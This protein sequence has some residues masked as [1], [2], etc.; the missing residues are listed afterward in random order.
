MESVGKCKFFIREKFQWLTTKENLLQFANMVVYILLFTKVCA[1]L[2]YGAES[3]YQTFRD[4]YF[5][6]AVSFF[7]IFILIERKVNLLSKPIFITSITYIGIYFRHFSVNTYELEYKADLQAQW[8]AWGLFLLVMVDIIKTG[9]R[10]TFNCKNKIFC[11]IMSIAF[12]LALVSDINYSLSM[13]CPFL[14]LY[15]T[16]ISKKRWEQIIDCFTIGYYIAFAK[17]MTISLIQVPYDIKEGLF[18]YYGIFLNI[19]TGGMLC[20]GAF[21]CAL[22]WFIKIIM[23]KRHVAMGVFLCLLAMFYS[24]FATTLFASRTAE[25]GIVCAMLCSLIFL[26]RKLEGKYWVKRCGVAFACGSAGL[27]LL[28]GVMYIVSE[29]G[30]DTIMRISNIYV[31][32]K[33]V[34]LWDVASRMLSFQSRYSYFENG[35]ILCAIDEASSFRLTTAIGGMQQVTWWGNRNMTF[36]I[37]DMTYMYPHNNY[38]T[39]MM[40]YGWIGGI[41]MI[42]WFFTSFVTATKRVIQKDYSSLFSFLWTSFLLMLMLAET[43]LWIYPVAFVLLMVQYP[44]LVGQE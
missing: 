5:S 31:R 3:M 29:V 14:A 32:T 24:L 8:W 12:M 19:A 26:S 44:L 37:C 15:T 17:I 21:V 36:S 1:Q 35:T 23:K 13:V 11:V 20:A 27:I 25:L 9:K 33:V 28:L 43:V 22:Y 16:P 30:Y 10:T 38:V 7:L 2:V 4:F 41:P 34:Y 42:I 18:K 6:K 39:W 40:M